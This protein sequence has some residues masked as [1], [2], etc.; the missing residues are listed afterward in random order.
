[1]T[2]A[3]IFAPREKPCSL[4]R[5]YSISTL[6][7]FH[8]S[9]IRPSAASQSRCA[10]RASALAR[11]AAFLSLIARYPPIVP[12]SAPNLLTGS[13]D[14]IPFRLPPLATELPAVRPHTFSAAAG[15]SHN[16]PRCGTPTFRNLR[17]PRI[18]VISGTPARMP[19]APLL[20]RRANF[21]SCDRPRDKRKRCAVRPAHD[22]LRARQQACAQPRPR[23]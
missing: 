14:R 3:V 13:A 16:L 18:V 7:R 6:P 4:S 23:R 9:R 5:C 21:P 10:P 8:Q 22:K 20:R 12:D 19:P 15:Q 1:S 11:L 2:L 17:C